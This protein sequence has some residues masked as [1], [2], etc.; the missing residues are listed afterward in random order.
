MR[1]KVYG[2]R[3]G[4]SFLFFLAVSIAWAGSTFNETWQL[5]AAKKTTPRVNRADSSPVGAV[6]D[7]GLWLRTYSGYDF[8][9]LGDLTRGMR[10]WVGTIRE[11][12]FYADS[13]T[14]NSGL[15]M[16]M[17]L[18][19]GL[20]RDN[21]FSLGFEGIL[22]QNQAF[23]AITPGGPFAQNYQPNL[24]GVSLNYYRYLA[25]GKTSRTY[26]SLGGGYY[27]A[28][29]D[30]SGNFGPTLLKASYEGN[31]IGGILGIGQEWS[32]GDGFGLEVTAHGR[33]VTVG[34]LTSPRIFVN[35]AEDSSEKQGLGKVMTG[36]YRIVVPTTTAN[37][38]SDPT[39]DYVTADFS[40]FDA[41]FTLKLYL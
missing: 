17:E 31:T 2:K 30:F 23:T 18:G 15:L 36:N 9:V 22:S 14:G 39:L 32:L 6:M 21:A 3:S 10:D 40:G 13:F 24:M 19:V 28:I 1:M 11:S 38:D 7:S 12:G 8:A 26:V 27:Q 4:I 41:N 16:G 29:V 35:G 5:A 25:V 20:D 37:I 34:Q 33:I